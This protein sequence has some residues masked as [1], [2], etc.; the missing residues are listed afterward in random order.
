MQKTSVPEGQYLDISG[1]VRPENPKM[2]GSGVVACRPQKGACL[3]R[4]QDCFFNGGR[5]YEDIAV[6]HIPDPDWVNG[7]G[8]VVR[9]NDGNDS[10]FNR[11]VVIDVARKYD[12]FFFN[13]RVPCLDFPGPVVLTV[14]GD[15]TDEAAWMVEPDLCDR[16]MAVRF[17]VNTWNLG[18]ARNVINY[19]SFLNVPVLLTFMAYYREDVKDPEGYVWKQ[20]T[21]NSYWV[22]KPEERAKVEDAL[23][24]VD[25]DEDDAVR[26]CTTRTG[27]RCADCR[28]CLDL[29]ERWCKRPG[30]ATS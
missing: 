2:A 24:V 25:E 17:R 14:N 11:D 12:R 5:Y 22:I 4:C 8:L 3:G 30:A 26:T 23:S 20:R 29:Y 21:L 13:T 15:Y 19:Y 1:E 18:L 28:N 9:M 27:H 6:P 7:N 16:L 10:N